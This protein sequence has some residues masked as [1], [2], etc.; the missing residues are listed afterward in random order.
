[1]AARRGHHTV[2]ARAFARDGDAASVAVTV[3][4]GRRATRSR[5]S[6]R[7]RL[8]SAPGGPGTLLQGTATPRRTVRVT[9]ARCGDR[10]GRVVRRMRLRSGR[11]GVLRGQLRSRG[12]CITQLR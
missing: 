10:R 11:R 4:R 9:L 8:A 6:R 1:M 7:W 5:S 2:S 12:L 3:V